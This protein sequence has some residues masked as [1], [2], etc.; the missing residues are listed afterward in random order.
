MN[1]NVINARVTF[2]NSPIHVLE[3]FTFKDIKNALLE[4]R[5]FSES[6]ECVI[7]Q[8]CNRIEIF[9]TGKNC[10]IK[11]IQKTWASLSGLEESAFKENLEIEIDD[12][13]YLHLLKLTSGLDSMVVGEEQ[14]LGQIKN[15][16]T[17]ARINKASGER[18]NTL[19]DKAI[20]IGTR[21]RNT[22]GIS[23]GGISVGS[24]AVKLAEE[25]IDELKSKQILVIG[26]GEV[27]TLVAKSLNRR[28]YGFS[29]TS[30]TL[31]RSQAFCETMGGQAVKFEE[32]LGGFEKYDV[33]FV[34]TTAPYFLVTY[35][36]IAKALKD[37]KK[38]MMILDL[39]N[40]R[41]VDEKVATLGNIKL[42]NL[43]QIA[44]MVDKNMRKRQDKVKIVENIIN[45]EL[46][47]I[48]ASMKRLDA[49]PIVKD[50]FKNIDVLRE[51]E[52]QKALQMLGENDSEKIKII[53]DLTKAVVES[54]VSA[55]MNN[56][57]KASEQGNPEILDAASKLF[58]Y[59][60][61][62]T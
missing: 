4:F 26:T 32:V 8:T 36:R 21:I 60:K 39:S 5:K 15:S 24:M 33:I 51:K 50:V 20:R 45:E 1:Q 52:L 44:E 2:R 49:E 12:E 13:A 11:K 53:E 56:L 18:L 62:E 22:T 61:K 16:I 7:L 55:P 19:F 57:R 25:N 48:E 14:I 3:R 17:T 38:G 28:G 37:K 47:V 54:I 59:K 46:Q 58:N 43:D 6:E 10:D 29:V 40:P 41:T 31:Q 34:A 42:M 9:A 35:E 27:S 30:R 23:K